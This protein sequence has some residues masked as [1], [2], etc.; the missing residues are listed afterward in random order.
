MAA[1]IITV[2][3][4][5]SDVYAAASLGIEYAGGR[6]GIDGHMKRTDNVAINATAFISDT[7]DVAKDNL[8]VHI[9]NS[10]GYQHFANCTKT[11]SVFSCSYSRYFPY[12]STGRHLF[13]VELYTGATKYDANAQPILAVSRNVSV[14]TEGAKVISISANPERAQT[15]ETSIQFYAE[16]YA[17]QEGTTGDCVGIDR[18]EFYETDYSGN[19][20]NVVH[21]PNPVCTFNSSFNYQAD[22]SAQQVTICAKAFDRFNQTIA[23]SKCAD[24]YIDSSAPEPVADSLRIAK[25]GTDETV[26]YIGQQTINVDIS[27]VIDAVDLVADSVVADLSNLAGDGYSSAPP[28]EHTDTNGTHTFR[29]TNIPIGSIEVCS[30]EITAEDEIGNTANSTVSCGIAIDNEGPEVAGITTPAIHESLYY[31][32]RKTTLTARIAEEGIG[33]YNEKIYMDLSNVL[34]GA[35]RVQADNCSLVEG[36]DWECYW[37]GVEPDAEDGQYYISIYKE[38]KDDL[39]NIME[40]KYEQLVGVDKVS[41]TINQ[42]VGLTVIPGVTDVPYPNITIEGDTLEF[43]IEVSDVYNA[44]ADFTPI[45]GDSAARPEECWRANQTYYCR[46]EVPIMNSGPYDADI[47]FTFSDFAG[48]RNSVTKSVFVSGLIDD[49]DPNFWQYNVTCSPEFVDRELASLMEFKSYCHIK[50]EPRNPNAELVSFGMEAYPSDC[51][52]ADNDTI[53]TDYIN[54]IV[55]INNYPG[56][57]HPHMDITLA[58][59][60]FNLDELKFSCDYT[61]FTKIG[62]QYTLH[63]EIETVT[64][65][66]EFYNLPSGRVDE[67]YERNVEKAM[68]QVE[69]IAAWVED[70][71]T[72]IEYA[73]ETCLLYEQ[74]C[75]A[76]SAL[77]LIAS[78][79]GIASEYPGFGSAFEGAWSA[80][81]Q[82]DSLAKQGILSE[83]KTIVDPIC[84]FVNC[85]Y[86]DDALDEIRKVLG[87]DITNAL[88]GTHFKGFSLSED[89]DVKRSIVWSTLTLCIPGVLRNVNKWKQIQCRYAVCLIRDVPQGYPKYICDDVKQQLECQYWWGQIFNLIPF[90]QI[91][92]NY[93]GLIQSYL[94]DPLSF[95]GW[96]VDIVFACSGDACTKAKKPYW[97]I[98]AITGLLSMIGQAVGDV[99]AIVDEGVY[100]DIGDAACVEYYELVE[101]KGG[102]L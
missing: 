54:N 4:Y 29:W 19:Q 43:V 56:S 61:I 28:R 85:K 31:L 93:M 49:P 82:G 20:V 96:V 52:P 89:F 78:I 102:F 62:D 58:V 3:V 14:D 21:P 90:V 87:K 57:L 18:V 30:F 8:R 73:E 17:T 46:W 92:S 98:C 15:G 55:M 59:T 35:T 91:F 7:D 37:Y 101:K 26:D 74:L 25:T 67:N 41:P 53:L 39:D 1:I 66:R 63:P 70:L 69:I 42:D 71:S 23:Q 72:I 22:S 99:G 80:A 50:L 44:T 94:S 27:I 81:C 84:G 76:L 16:D 5:V 12:T 97:F 11:G 9:D 36:S 95:I 60:E 86:S 34:S 83:V 33:L 32:G 68:D 10:P 24:F 13:T 75:N 64:V 6:D 79:F 47:E 100:Q 77:T 38:S 88:A 40:S 65:S 2:P 48:N 51:Y 45:G